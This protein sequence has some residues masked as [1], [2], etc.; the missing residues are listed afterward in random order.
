MMRAFVR[1]STRV[2]VRALQ[3]VRTATR[4][5]DRFSSRRFQS[6][7]T[8]GTE[9][10]ADQG[11]EHVKEQAEDGAAVEEEEEQP[12][13]LFR[14]PDQPL[15]LSRLLG[16]Q[17]KGVLF[18]V[19]VGAS[20]HEA[21]LGA[22]RAAGA[23][24]G[25]SAVAFDFPTGGALAD[26][27]EG[28]QKAVATWCSGDEETPVE[29]NGCSAQWLAADAGR[30][31]WVL[32]QDAASKTGFLI[33][34][35]GEA[36]QTVQFTDKQKPQVRFTIQLGKGSF[37]VI[38]SD[39]LE[40][41]KLSA[42]GQGSGSST[43]LVSATVVGPPPEKLGKLHASRVQADSRSQA[44][45]WS[46]PVARPLP[47]SRIERPRYE[48]RFQNTR[49]YKDEGLVSRAASPPETDQQIWA[50]RL[51]KA[52]A[53]DDLHLLCR[54]QDLPDVIIDALVERAR[55]EMINCNPVM[56]E[57][58]KD[59]VFWAPSG[60]E[61]DIRNRRLIPKLAHVIVESASDIDPRVL[62]FSVRCLLG[63]I[64]GPSPFFKERAEVL[65]T[66][67][68]TIG[69]R[70]IIDGLDK[71]SLSRLANIVKWAILRNNDRIS[72]KLGGKLI[73][74]AAVRTHELTPR[75]MD[76][77]MWLAA[78]R[79]G[80][81]RYARFLRAFMK[82]IHEWLVKVPEV[83]PLV[84]PSVVWSGNPP[85]SVPNWSVYTLVTTLTDMYSLRWDETPQ[86]PIGQLA[87]QWTTRAIV[88]RGADNRKDELMHFIVLLGLHEF[89]VQ[90]LRAL[91]RR[92]GY[93]LK[94][95]LEIVQT[96]YLSSQ[97]PLF[98]PEGILAAE[99][100]VVLKA[101]GP[102]CTELIAELSKETEHYRLDDLKELRPTV[103]RLR[104]IES[105]GAPETSPR[106][107]D[108]K[109]RQNKRTPDVQPVDF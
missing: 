26:V 72:G 3:P 75:E 95:I 11:T 76:S 18:S 94:Q 70:G 38:P 55:S 36:D 78:R 43:L 33:L 47:A 53:L 31:D 14:K 88:D 44:D 7:A 89:Y 93:E 109:P 35:L 108:R 52:A 13:E 29:F 12:R 37:A 80:R 87:V 56:F 46:R 64:D 74:V 8:A 25:G 27:A 90:P 48:P 1:V 63:S 42:V 62:V 22:V 9:V 83:H 21:L 57:G 107:Q 10:P 54:E 86:H 81:S 71:M 32:P 15:E 41:W 4:P 100:L 2:G 45:S 58:V 104:L 97:R 34:A 102:F 28:I 61:R 39:V 101:I 69:D 105:G 59:S 5:G 96:A 24:E 73:E 19:D 67:M 40:T 106:P 17:R 103:A 82:H 66:L 49:T 51:I 65:D 20:E 85:G 79:K 6:N 98:R 23:A 50:E 77:I 30:E 91:S 84:D 60:K 92:D 99:A 68:D 16:K